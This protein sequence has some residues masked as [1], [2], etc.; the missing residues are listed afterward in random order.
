MAGLHVR[1]DRTNPALYMW[2]DIMT[3]DLPPTLMKR[4]N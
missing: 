2:L 4:G 3:K 1:R